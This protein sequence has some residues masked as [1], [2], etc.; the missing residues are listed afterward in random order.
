MVER[1]PGVVREEIEERPYYGDLLRN[2]KKWESGPGL[3]DDLNV[4]LIVSIVSDPYACQHFHAIRY[5]VFGGTK[6][7]VR[8][9]DV[10]YPRLNLTIG[11]VYNEQ[12]TQASR[13]A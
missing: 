7:K 1:V 3:N 8:S 6:W 12:Q 2:Q 11:G 13:E 4:D 5:V 10:Q 9:V